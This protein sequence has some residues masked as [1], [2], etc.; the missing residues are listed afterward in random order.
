MRLLAAAWKSFCYALG[1]LVL[2]V[3]LVQGWYV[4]HVWWWASHTPGN[5][6]FME[7]RLDDLRAKDPQ[8]RLK[9]KRAGPLNRARKKAGVDD[10]NDP[11]QKGARIVRARLP[12]EQPEMRCFR[13]F[14]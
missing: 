6:S 8:A 3:L 1:A 10:T 2:A 9:Q 12:I 7:F 14:H 5:T 4:A 13:A 11:P